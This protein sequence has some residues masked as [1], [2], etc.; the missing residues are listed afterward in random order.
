MTRPPLRD[1]M[2]HVP[3]PS[4]ADDGW[5]FS[6]ESIGVRR[7]GPFT[8]ERA[9]QRAREALF[10]RWAAVATVRGGWAWKSTT[11]RWVVTLPRTLPVDALPLATDPCTHH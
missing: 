11:I 10:K 9:A 1:W 7:Y 3:L 4:A 5:W 8:T 6:V 2:F